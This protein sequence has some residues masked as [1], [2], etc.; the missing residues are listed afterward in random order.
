M[1]FFRP[2]AEPDQLF[3]KPVLKRGRLGIGVD[4]N[5]NSLHPGSVLTS[6]VKHTD[7]AIYAALML[8]RRGIWRDNYKRLGLEQE[9]VGIVFD[10]HN[11]KFG[12]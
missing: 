10:E 4:I 7:K 2:Q 6:M 11:K 1:L 12:D 5:Q 8:A 9:A 3:L